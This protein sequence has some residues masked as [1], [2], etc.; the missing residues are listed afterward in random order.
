MDV[1]YVGIPNGLHSLHTIKAAEKDKRVSR[2]D[3]FKARRLTVFDYRL[4]QYRNCN[5]ICPAK[6]IPSALNEIGEGK[7]EVPSR[8]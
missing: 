1:D 3:Y 4:R 2:N 7:K 8:E 5:S 6:F